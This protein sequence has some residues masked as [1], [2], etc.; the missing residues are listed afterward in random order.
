[1]VDDRAALKLGRAI[2]PLCVREDEQPSQH[3][4]SDY[5]T[6]QITLSK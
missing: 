2:L 4:S 1:V 3:R 6:E 5:V